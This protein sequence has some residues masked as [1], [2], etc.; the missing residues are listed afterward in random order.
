LGCRRLLDL[1]VVRL[2]AGHV[3]GECGRGFDKGRQLLIDPSALSDGGIQDRLQRLIGA[4]L[5][6]PTIIARIARHLGIAPFGVKEFFRHLGNIVH[7][8]QEFV[9]HS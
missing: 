4:S 3:V 6:A 7:V 8:L 9:E 2:P 1:G 5:T